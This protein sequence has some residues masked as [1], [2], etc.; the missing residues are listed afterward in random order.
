MSNLVKSIPDFWIVDENT[1]VRTPSRFNSS[2]LIDLYKEHLGDRLRFNLLK[3]EL[4]V[5]GKQINDLE[6]SLLYMH[7]ATKGIISGQAASKDALWTAGLLNQFNPVQ[8]YLEQVEKNSLVYPT[9]INS[10]SSDFLKTSDQLFDRMMKVFLIGAVKRAFERG[11][12]FDTMLVIKGEQGIGKSTF[13]RNLVPNET[14]FSDTPQ[15][16]PKQ[17]LMHLQTNWLVEIAELEQLT[18]K[19]E[20][21]ELKALLSSA[22]DNFLAP[23]GRK[24]TRADRPSVMVGTCNKDNFLNDPS[25]SRRFH[26]IRLTNNADQKIDNELVKAERD[27]IW[28][29]AIQSYR[30]GEPSYLSVE[31]QLLSEEYNG[32]YQIEN[33]YYSKLAEWINNAPDMFTLRMALEYSKIIG[34]DQI[35]KKYDQQLCGEALRELG[36]DKVQKRVNGI[37][38]RYWYKIGGKADPNV[39]KSEGEKVTPK[40]PAV[41][42][43]KD[44]LSPVP[45]SINKEGKAQETQHKASSCEDS[46]ELV[47]VTREDGKTV[48]GYNLASPTTTEEERDKWEKER[49]KMYDELEEFWKI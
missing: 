29:A 6:E 43:N 42:S 46:E 10:V 5:D 27:A 21:G 8:D 48:I 36:F 45:Y 25:G 19:T 13:F 15:T 11:C 44:E 47:T 32:D 14:W 40:T 31:D 18:T 3:L 23:Y 28:K 33:P 38:E 39:P 22:T 20:A 41:S 34:S 7:L 2:Q 1:Q 4:E 37:R 12:K 17:R 24:M 49:N 16:N 9:N 35:P 26:I 30:Q